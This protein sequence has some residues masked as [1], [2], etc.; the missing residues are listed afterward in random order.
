VDVNAADCQPGD[1]VLDAAGKTWQRG[2]RP[3]RWSTFSG[4]VGYY[5]PW[6]AEYGPVGELTLLVRDGQPVTGDA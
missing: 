4:P 2:D 1:V 5:G 6:K 3:Y